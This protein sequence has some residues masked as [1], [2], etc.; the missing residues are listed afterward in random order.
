[1]LCGLTVGQPPSFKIPV[2]LKFRRVPPACEAKGDFS[3][4]VKFTQLL[5]QMVLTFLTRK[6]NEKTRQGS[7]IHVQAK[8]PVCCN[9][10]YQT[11][12]CRADAV[13]G[14]ASALRFPK[15]C[16]RSDCPNR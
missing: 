7:V 13:E 1:M 6:G 15:H 14:F 2:V 12:S 11:L 9:G 5:I 16:L 8:S 3:K 4:A 10:P